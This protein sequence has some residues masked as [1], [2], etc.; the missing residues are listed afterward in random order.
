MQ[1]M[2]SGIWGGRLVKVGWPAEEHGGL[3]LR[4]GI[5]VGTFV[6]NGVV[7]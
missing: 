1:G 2:G 4:S 6:G 7:Q 5:C 3:G